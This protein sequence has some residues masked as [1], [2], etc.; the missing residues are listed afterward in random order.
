MSSE[1]AVH[2]FITSKMDYC[3]SFLCGCRKVQLQKLLTIRLE[4]CHL[5]PESLLRLVN[6]NTWSAAS[7]HDGRVFSSSAKINEI[8]F[9]F[10]TYFFNKNNL[11]EFKFSFLVNFISY[12]L[13]YLIY[14]ILYYHLLRFGETN[15]MKRK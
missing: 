2:A 14:L 13:F 12:L 10:L 11:I 6:L 7:E 9:C 8:L 15:K 1:I 3:N 5:P 4:H